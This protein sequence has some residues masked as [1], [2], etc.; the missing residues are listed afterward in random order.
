ML[1]PIM[2]AMKKT[3][4]VAL[5]VLGALFGH[6]TKAEADITFFLGFHASP[7]TQSVRGVSAGVNLLIV[8]FEFEYG[9]TREDTTVGKEAPGLQTG[10]ANFVVMTP[11]NL[12]LYA[13]IGA[14][15][16]REDLGPSHI[17][18]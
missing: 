1:H 11:T 12:S 3:L 10:M 4:A 13:T 15:I 14:G 18:N 17:T 2:V 8:G 7:H 5:L 16:Y 9:L 6:A